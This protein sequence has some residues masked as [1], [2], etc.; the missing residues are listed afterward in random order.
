MEPRGVQ[1]S[2]NTERLNP[3]GEN[4]GPSKG[5]RTLPPLN[6]EFGCVRRTWTTPINDIVALRT[7]RA[8]FHGHSPTFGVGDSFKWATFCVFASSFPNKQLGLGQ[9]STTRPWTAGFRQLVS[10]YQ[11]NPFWEHSH[12]GTLV[13]TPISGTRPFTF[14][15]SRLFLTTTPKL[16]GLVTRAARCVWPRQAAPQLSG[17][18]VRPG[19]STWTVEDLA[20]G[21]LHAERRC[22]GLELPML[23]IYSRSPAPFW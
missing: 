17:L 2:E 19:L 5:H 1:L 8:S 14:H 9:N 16:G 13:N 15:S 22:H 18:P 3:R 20:G 7:L 23:K 11:G 12:F 4:Q 6:R 10:V 21:R